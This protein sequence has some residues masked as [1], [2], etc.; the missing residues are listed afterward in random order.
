MSR[1][2]C[3][4]SF[5]LPICTVGIGGGWALFPR[6]PFPSASPPFPSIL[7]LPPLIA[8]DARLLWLPPCPPSPV[9]STAWHS[10]LF[11][12]LSASLSLSPPP[13]LPLLSCWA[14]A[15]SSL[16]CVSGPP[17]QPDLVHIQMAAKV[18]LPLPC[19]PP[20]PGDPP[21]WGLLLPHHPVPITLPASWGNQC[22]RA[23]G[24][25]ALPLQLPLT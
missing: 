20:D 23:L 22:R 21:C 9:P 2:P 12:A 19:S 13:S 1:G 16:L 8:L 11:L 24:T 4:S 17:L 3:V 25:G 15:F 18:L 10:A 6:Q 14:L 7:S 5:S